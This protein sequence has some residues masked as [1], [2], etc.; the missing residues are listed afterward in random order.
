MPKLDGLQTLKRLRQSDCAMTDVSVIALTADA[1]IGDKEKYLN[2]GFDGYVAKPINERDL[3]SEASR[4]L[5]INR[6]DV[7]AD[8]SAVS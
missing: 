1:M 8:W 4:I 5:G 2:A 6:A 3:I 7:R